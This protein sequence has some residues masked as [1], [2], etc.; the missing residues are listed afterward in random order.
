M[1]KYISYM[2]RQSHIMSEAGLEKLLEN[3]RINNSAMG[4]TGLLVSYQG[5]F[6]QYI[7]G[8]PGLIDEL[9]QKIKKDARH[10]SVVELDS[11]LQQDRQFSN[12][13]MAFRQLDH[14]KAEKILGYRDFDKNEVFKGRREYDN[15]H[16]TR[17]LNS[18]VNNL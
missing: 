11:G 14:K 9:F 8:A 18:F 10:H 17:L 7:E 13:S 5:I 15:H 12:W 2:S 16:A 6:I 1:Y 3:C 4:I